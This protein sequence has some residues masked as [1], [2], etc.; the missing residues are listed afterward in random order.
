[1]FDFI[2][3][4][5]IM[6]NH[7]YNKYIDNMLNNFNMLS[8]KMDDIFN[9]DIKREFLCDNSESKEGND[10]A[11]TD[12][13]RDAKDV[14]DNKEDNNDLDQNFYSYESKYYSHIEENSNGE[15]VR[16][17]YHKKDI[18]RNGQHQIIETKRIGNKS[19]TQKIHK[20]KEGKTNSQEFY[21]NINQDDTEDI[22]NFNNEWNEYFNN[23]FMMPS[24][25]LSYNDENDKRLE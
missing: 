18:N 22:N 8:K 25:F 3:D 11:K 23:R 6:S 21:D 9:E 16:H 19:I 15:P 10:D 24:S 1:M 5:M 14:D 17:Y 13:D 7:C 12:V 20:D 2:D 4:M